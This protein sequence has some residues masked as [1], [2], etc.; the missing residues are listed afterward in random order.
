VKRVKKS[1]PLFLL[2]FLA[3]SIAKTFAQDQ[4]GN[5]WFFGNEVGIRF[6]K[7]NNEAIVINNQG[8]PLNSGGSAVVSDPITGKVLFYTD[9]VTVYDASGQ[10]MV[11]G[12]GLAA[13]DN[14]NQPV[15]ISPVPVE[16]PP[17]VSGEYEP[18][19]YYVFSNSSN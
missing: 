5:T 14:I 2:L 9:G 15:A 6:T 11:N 19:Q 4:K 18:G 17:G 8:S 7:P 16:V 3:F 1:T 12:S 13:A 10:V